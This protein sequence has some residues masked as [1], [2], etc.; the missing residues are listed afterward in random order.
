MLINGHCR[1]EYIFNYGELQPTAS[2][3]SVMMKTRPLIICYNASAKSF[4][5]LFYLLLCKYLI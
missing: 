4:Y 3:K 5:V 1:L 2:A